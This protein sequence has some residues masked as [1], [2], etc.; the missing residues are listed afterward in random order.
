[1]QN[2]PARAFTLIELLVVIAIISILA[3]ILFPV[4]AQAR[5]A[6]RRT[7]CLSNAKQQ[8]LALNMYVQDYDERLPTL[9]YTYATSDFVDFW[10]LYQPYVKNIDLF[11]CPDRAQTGCYALEDLPE[12]LAS[13]RCIGYGFNWGPAQSFNTYTNDGGLLEGGGDGP[14]QA[15]FVGITLSQIAAPAEC[16]AGGDTTDEPW[17]T[18]SI[19][20]ELADFQGSSNSALLHGGRYNMLYCDGH[21]KV[22][23]W[24]GAALG[25]AGKYISAGFYCP[26]GKIAVPKNQADWTRWCADPSRV[27][28]VDKGNGG[29]QQMACGQIAAAIAASGPQ[30][31]PDN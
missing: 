12:P 26:Y 4:F 30:W 8:G 28:T 13:R 17:F 3:A 10:N 20:S 16:F 22:M 27:L 7:S 18:V 23:E 1:M 11:F 6:A 25:Q 14:T 24:K 5:E 29:T 21:A 19:M 31:Y 15:V 2:T 9:T